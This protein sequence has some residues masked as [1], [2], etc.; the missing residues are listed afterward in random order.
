M[1]GWQKP[2]FVASTVTQV[3]F[4][5]VLLA[6][7]LFYFVAAGR[8]LAGPP[9]AGIL[10]GLAA[11]GAVMMAMLVALAFTL[12][13]G[14]LVLHVLRFRVAR[15][16]VPLAPLASAIALGVWLASDDP[17]DE[18]AVTVAFVICLGCFLLTSASAVAGLPPKAAATRPSDQR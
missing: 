2:L 15:F 10:V 18:A 5:L 9:N 17:G 14:G 11:A 8:V 13:I 12:T 3:V 4:S 1:S 7:F 16:F 6:A